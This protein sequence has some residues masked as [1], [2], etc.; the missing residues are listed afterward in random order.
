[1]NIE[2]IPVPPLETNCYVAWADGPD[3]LVID[4]GGAPDRIA[5]L[6]RKKGLRPALYVLT[7][8]HADHVGALSKL[9]AIFPAPAAI[10]RDD[11]HWAF[12]PAVSA[13]RPRRRPPPHGERPPGR[14]S[15]GPRR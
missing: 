13:A 8:G 2:T 6:L 7:H 11:A 10:G 1:M 14:P 12:T 4:P 9:E 5:G 3:A 15:A